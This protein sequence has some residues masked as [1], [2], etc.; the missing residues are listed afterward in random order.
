MRYQFFGCISGQ[1]RRFLTPFRQFP[2]PCGHWDDTKSP[3]QPTGR[4]IFIT[5]VKRLI[6]TPNTCPFSP[7]TFQTKPFHQYKCHYYWS[8]G[9][10]YQLLEIQVAKLS[11]QVVREQWLITGPTCFFG[12][13]KNWNTE[14]CGWSS[15]AVVTGGESKEDKRH[16]IKKNSTKET[17]PWETTQNWHGEQKKVQTWTTYNPFE[18]HSDWSVVR[19]K[20][21]LEERAAPKVQRMRPSDPPR[22]TKNSSQV[23]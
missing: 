22:L 15:L 17:F 18:W 9:C 1:K 19:G 14:S 8:C 10:P 5:A 23:D 13:G 20:G 2:T 3:K 7:K 21:I 16:S 11:I 12:K 6:Q 4:A